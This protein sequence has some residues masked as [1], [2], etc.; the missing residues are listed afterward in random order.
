MKARIDEN[1][2]QNEISLNKGLKQLGEGYFSLF[3]ADA[4][5]TKKYE[6]L[7]Q[8]PEEAKNEARLS[9]LKSMNLTPNRLQSASKMKA[10]WNYAGAILSAGAEGFVYYS[11]AYYVLGLEFFASVVIALFPFVFTKLIQAQLLPYIKKWIKENNTKIKS[12]FKVLLFCFVA[13]ILVNSVTGGILNKINIDRTQ[14]QEH[15]ALLQ[16]ED[17]D[18]EELDKA[19]AQLEDP[20]PFDDIVGF[21]AIALLGL[22]AIPA[23]A[24]LWALGD[25]YRQALVLRKRIDFLRKE[26]SRI[27]SNFQYTDSTRHTLFALQKEIISFYG[28]KNYYERLMSPEEKNDEKTN[29]G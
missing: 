16:E 5:Y 3:K 2:I 28:L 13:L 8:T 9:V 26:L 29:S 14:E 17:P 6:F 20:S 21:L 15:I 19:L 4:Q 24:F 18:S 12:W 10:V 7:P 1:S 27:R 25:F 11:I 22:L 23:G